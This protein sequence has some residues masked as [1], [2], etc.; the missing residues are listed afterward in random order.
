MDKDNNHSQDIQKLQAFVEETKDGKYSGNNVSFK[1]ILQCTI[2]REDVSYVEDDK[3]QNVGTVL[4]GI[5]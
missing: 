3:V 2:T 5:Y 4:Y 1:E